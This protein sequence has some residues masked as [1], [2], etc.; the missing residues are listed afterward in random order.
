MRIGNVQFDSLDLGLIRVKNCELSWRY[1]HPLRQAYQAQEEE[2]NIHQLA[3][4]ARQES[5]G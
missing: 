1:D 5:I 4:W 2:G 3:R